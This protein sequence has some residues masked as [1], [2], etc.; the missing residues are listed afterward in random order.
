MKKG[1]TP[2]SALALLAR[3]LRERSFSEAHVPGK[4]I[5]FVSLPAGSEIRGGA[6]L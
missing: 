6:P 5:P 3:S 4:T 1:C 2:L